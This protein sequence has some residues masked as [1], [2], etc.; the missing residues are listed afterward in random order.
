MTRTSIYDR[1][2]ERRL[3]LEE[4]ARVEQ[5]NPLPVA[6]PEP[7]P[8][9]V[10]PLR[11][12]PSRFSFGGFD[13]SLPDSFRF[14][15]IQTTI[16]HDGEPVVLTI[17]RRDVREGAT[18]DVL[19]QDAMQTFRKLYPQLRVIRER[20]CSLAGSPAKAVDFHFTMGHAERHGRLV[21]GIVPVADGQ[22]SQWLSLSCVIDPVK[23]SL[24]LWLVDFDNMLSGMA[25]R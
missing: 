2:S 9:P 16:E 18:L 13:L 3:A 21:G 7:E 20:D 19:L 10:V 25:T 1:I 8:E 14:R 24:S 17:K 12:V 5:Q 23:P 11:D 15:D 22:T 6:E 4:A